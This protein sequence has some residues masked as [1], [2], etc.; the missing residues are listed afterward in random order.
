M[1]VTSRPRL[2]A[3]GLEPGIEDPA[4]G[5]LARAEADHRGIQANGRLIIGRLPLCFDS[6]ECPERPGVGRADQVDRREL[7]AAEGIGHILLGDDRLDRIDAQRPFHVN[8]F[9]KNEQC[10]VRRLGLEEADSLE[11]FGAELGILI[12]HVLLQAGD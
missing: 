8:I 5:A 2:A 4:E 11:Q 7:A 10:F 3:V 12:G 1:S 6:G 9:L